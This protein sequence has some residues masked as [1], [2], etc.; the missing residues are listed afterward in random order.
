[1][2]LKLGINRE[3]SKSY[4]VFQCSIIPGRGKKMTVSVVSFPPHHRDRLPCIKKFL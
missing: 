3:E 4:S 2:F 1:M